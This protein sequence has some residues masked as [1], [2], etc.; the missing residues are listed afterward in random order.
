M[1]A[2]AHPCY[3]QQSRTLVDRL[4]ALLATRDVVELHKCVEK[5]NEHFCMNNAEGWKS[6]RE[7]RLHVLLKNII[8]SRSTYS[9]ATYCSSVLSFLADIV[10]YASGLDKRVEDPVIDQLLAWGDKFWERLLTMLET[11]AASSRLH[12]SLGNSLA[13][14]TLAYHNL[15]CERDRIPNLIMSHFGNLVVYAWLYRLGSGQDDRALHIFD[16]LLRHAKPSECSTFC[17]NFI[18]TAKSDQIAQRFRHEFNQTRLPSVNFRTSLHIMAYLGGFGVGSLNSVLSALVGHDVYKSLF[19]A[20]NR[21]IDRDEPR[22]EWAAIGR[23]PYFLW[24]LFINSI[25]RSTSKSHRHFEYLMAFMSRAAVIG[26]GFDNDDTTMYI[27]KWLQ[28]IINIRDFASGVKNKEPKG[29]L[30]KD[31]RYLAR[32]HWDDSVGPALGAYM[33]RP[34]ETRVHKNAKKMWDAW[35]DMGMAIGL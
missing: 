25:D 34:T 9:D 31:M 6:L 27:K 7:T 26:P 13:E 22:E 35:F 10:E 4:V 8:M 28:L 24:S 23:A 30:I 5:A 18:E 15:Y 14:L 29:A 3:R 32:R 1:S 12:P 20:L 19:E 11:I 16:N 2:M 17:Q 21:Q 33:R